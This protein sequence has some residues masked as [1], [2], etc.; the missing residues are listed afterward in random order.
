MNFY[1]L[2]LYQM[3]SLFTVFLILLFLGG[4]INLGCSTNDDDIPCGFHNG[5]Q[6]YLGPKGGCYYINTNNNK[7]YVDRSECNC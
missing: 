4:S 6:L 7:E 3:K 1:L 5:K 2:N